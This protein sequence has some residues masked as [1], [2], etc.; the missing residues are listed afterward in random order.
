[1]PDQFIALDDDWREVQRTLKKLAPDAAKAMNRAIRRE[2][3]KVQADARRGYAEYSTR[4]GRAVGVSV[5]SKHVALRL[6]AKKAPHGPINEFGGRHPVFGN[7]NV[8]VEQEA[9]PRLEPAVDEHREPIRERI[10]E[11]VID[12]A[13]QLGFK[14]R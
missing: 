8:W 14:T 2:A 3:K 1:M 5:S 7:R 9:R 12:A 4:I 6:S 11:E 13:R 10:A